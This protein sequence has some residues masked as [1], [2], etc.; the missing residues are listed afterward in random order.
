M[1]AGVLEVSGGRMR[2]MYTSPVGGGWVPKCG[3][4]GCVVRWFFARRVSLAELEW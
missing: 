4:V 2:A 1:A 3:V